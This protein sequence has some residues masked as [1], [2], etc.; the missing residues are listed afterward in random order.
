MT[1][2]APLASHE[3]SPSDNSL[4][5]LCVDDEE[6]ILKALTRLFRRESFRVFTASSGKEA[7]AILK[8][9][10]NIGL[11]LSDYRMP[12][13]TGTEFLR[14]ATTLAPDIPKMILSGHADMNSAL[15]AIN[16]GGVSRFLTKPWE[17]EELLQAV[18]DG[19]Q[20]YELAQQNLRLTAVILQQKEELAEWNT[21]LKARVLHQ[22]ATI[23]KQLEE[24][25]RQQVR[26][27]NKSEA[28]VCLLAELLDQRH[29]RLSR[30]S[31]C[32]SALAASMAKSLE[33]PQ[34]E[35]IRQ[36]AL[37]HD[38]GL[39]GVSDR[40]LG[41]NNVELLRSDASYRLHP[42]KG[43]ETIDLI[44]EMQGIGR[45]VRHHHEEFDGSGFPDGL[46]GEDIPLGSRIIH[47][48][49][50]I[51]N[52]YSLYTG[53]DAKYQLSKKVNAGMGILFDPTL[54]SAANLAMKEV[55]VG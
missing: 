49:S 48:A 10:E 17:D 46:A 31:R 25:H 30:H 22:S 45:L 54:A 43:Q 21:N 37:L 23:R 55:L 14:A 16:Q 19:L 7:L 11:I 38:L 1:E 18:R 50:Y 26:D 39:I 51:D 32:V 12:E 40:V 4:A 6:A 34:V 47:L 29:H 13:M 15:D 35:E 5:I 8:S 41:N 36:A 53:R 27:P 33:L 28:I 9:T 20:R 44:P 3:E 42:V 52:N 24:A 2:N